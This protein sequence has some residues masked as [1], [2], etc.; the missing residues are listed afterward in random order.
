MSL[1]PAPGSA[2]VGSRAPVR[3][4]DPEI[5]W[6]CRAFRAPL[7]ASTATAVAPPAQLAQWGLEP[8]TLVE[9]CHGAARV[10]AWL[11]S[12][13]DYPDVTWD[14]P[15]HTGHHL[16]LSRRAREALGAGTEAANDVKLVIPARAWLEYGSARIDDLP[17]GTEVD[18][19]DEVLRELGDR[20][21]QALL[22]T[23]GL[24][25]PVR[26]RG[27][28][29]DPQQ[30]RLSMLARSLL[31]LRHPPGGRSGAGEAGAPP[32]EKKVLLCALPPEP[33]APA[34]ARPMVHGARR[35]VR[36]IMFGVE[37]ALGPV[38][39]A[40]CFAFRTTEALVADD[41]HSVVRL[42]AASFPLIGIRPGDQVVLTWARR[43][44]VA[45]ALEQVPL[46]E[47]AVEELQRQQMVDLRAPRRP[48]D[49]D[50]ITIEVAASI[51]HVLGISRETVL[52]VHRRVWPQVA[53]RVNALLLPAG[54]LLLAAAAIQGFKP[55]WTW[56][57]MTAIVAAEMLHLRLPSPPRGRW[58]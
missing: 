33:S 50:H 23:S 2:A 56:T 52:Q 1:A 32:P 57:G 38:L 14:V 36:F 7:R 6:E 27:R 44:V 4:T 54:G 31:R 42:P 41:V 21:G 26:L 51:R 10:L 48:R 15:A 43:A 11:H 22:V 3:V 25:M 47:S 8:Q 5:A 30:I 45:I 16:W 18:V 40:P 29:V 13:S 19:A 39:G 37:R 28:D 12:T 46:S 35:A 9:L 24:C 20:D 58:N 55:L 17:R 53:V 34:G 49:E